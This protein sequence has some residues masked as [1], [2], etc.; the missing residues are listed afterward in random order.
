[1]KP[2]VWR[3]GYALRNQRVLLSTHFE[4]ARRATSP[5]PTRKVDGYARPYIIL[6]RILT[7]YQ[8]SKYLTLL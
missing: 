7:G 1:M 2:S 6:D 4:K 5:I 3:L 8:K